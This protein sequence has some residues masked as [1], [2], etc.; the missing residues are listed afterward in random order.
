MEN[1]LSLVP[2]E[3]LIYAAIAI[4]LPS[5]AGLLLYLKTEKDAIVDFVVDEVD[6]V[7]ADLNE[8]KTAIVTALDYAEDALEGIIQGLSPDSLG[9][10]R[11]TEEEKA[12]SLMM[13]NKALT[14]LKNAKNK[15]SESIRIGD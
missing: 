4:L 10:S 7:L 14:E 12:E 6:D 1:I 2:V 11:L 8:A 13:A 15:I 3:Q 9:G 5:V